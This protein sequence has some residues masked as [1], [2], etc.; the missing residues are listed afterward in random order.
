M[1][2]ITMNNIPLSFSTC[3]INMDHDSYCN[4][5]IKNINFQME[6][7]AS[8]FSLEMNDEYVET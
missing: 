2:N 6:K 4:N 7:I 8:L 1:I 5:M 3:T